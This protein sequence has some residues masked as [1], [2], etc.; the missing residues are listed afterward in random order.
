LNPRLE[1]ELDEV[2]AALLVV[3]LADAPL[4]CVPVED[5]R[6]LL[7]SGLAAVVLPVGPADSAEGWLVSRLD[8]TAV[9]PLP[10]LDVTAADCT[11]VAEGALS[12]VE[13]V[14]IVNTPSVAVCSVYTPSARLNA[15]EYASESPSEVAARSS[16]PSP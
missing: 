5:G 2:A 16:K 15:P 10:L 12:C 13:L 6:A 8:D 3:E 1:F 14:T 9:L 11:D 4:D 7:L